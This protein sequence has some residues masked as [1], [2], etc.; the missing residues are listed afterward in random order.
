MRKKKF[1]KKISP[2]ATPQNEASKPMSKFQF[3]TSDAMRG[4]SAA[5]VIAEGKKRGMELSEK[6]I[7]TARSVA[8]SRRPLKRDFIA[9]SGVVAASGGVVSSGGSS[10]RV[11]NHAAEQLLLSVAG[12]VGLG[13]SIELLTEQRAKVQSFLA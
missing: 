5:E 7:Y 9:G 8:K 2:K 6:Y 4:K 11:G 13:R 3:I 12:E 10:W 1:P